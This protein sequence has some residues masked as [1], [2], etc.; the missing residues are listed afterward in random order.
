MISFLRTVLASTAFAELCARNS[1]LEAL[2]VALLASRLLTSAAFSVLKL[3]TLIFSDLDFEG[4]RI[5]LH[6]FSFSALYQS[7]IILSVATVFATTI[8]ATD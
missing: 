4:L 5:S 2:A 8:D 3:I 6:N 7:I 1:E